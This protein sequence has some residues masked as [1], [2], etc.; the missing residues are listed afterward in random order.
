MKKYILA[1]GIIFL[2]ISNNIYSRKLSPDKRDF[3]NLCS[4]F[5]AYN[6][7]RIN[8]TNKVKTMFRT[9]A[10]KILRN[11]PDSPYSYFIKGS[12]MGKR[13]AILTAYEKWPNMPEILFITGQYYAITK[14]YEK[15]HY[16]YDKILEK[17]NRFIYPKFLSLIHYYKGNVYRFQSKYEKALIQYRKALRIFP[18]FV[19]SFIN[20]GWIYLNI[21]NRH[22]KAFP[23]FARASKIN[24]AVYQSHLNITDIYLIEARKIY[25]TLTPKQKKIACPKM[26]KYL[27]GAWKSAMKAVKY[28][29]KRLKHLGFSYINK[30]YRM[31]CPSLRGTLKS[32]AKSNFYHYQEGIRISSLS[33]IKKPNVSKFY[34]AKLK[35]ITLKKGRMIFTDGRITLLA[36]TNRNTVIKSF[37]RGGKKF[38]VTFNVIAIQREKGN[39]TVKI[40]GLLK[41][42]KSK[43]K[44]Y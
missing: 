38:V 34:S 30:T 7:G 29:P 3:Y 37:L 19:K 8:M 23:C 1:V 13:Q 33:E 42:V 21:Q 6:A 32:I 10:S 35:W 24:P 31:M 20:I 28:M 11:Y 5:V 16:Y 44:S 41:H 36:R 15:A 22:K 18:T 26:D 17:H 12:L 43:F 27:M 14:D 4:W 39:G 40:Y 25:V 9:I 2:I